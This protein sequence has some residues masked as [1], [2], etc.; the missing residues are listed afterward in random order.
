MTTNGLL[1][2]DT[3]ST[4]YEKGYPF[5][6]PNRL[7]CVGTLHNG[8]LRYHDIEYSG[9]PYGQTLNLL[10]QLI[11]GSRLL[12]GFNLKHDLHWLRRY[13]PDIVFPT[14]WDCQLAEFI[15]SSQRWPYPSLDEACRNRG[16]DPK[17]D[18]IK[19]NYWDVG[20]DTDKVP[21]A[22]L[23][24]YQ[25]KDVEL[26]FQLYRIQTTLLEGNQLRLFQLQNDDLQTLADIEW[27]GMDYDFDESLR[28]GEAVKDELD[29]CYAALKE[30]EPCPH[31]NWNSNKHLS[32]VLYGG[33]IN[34]EGTEI[35]TKLYKSGPKMVER[36]AQL[37]IDFPQLVKPMKGTET[38]PTSRWDDS[39]LQNVNRSRRE[40]R[41]TQIGRCYET[42]EGVLKSLPAR[43]KA[44]KIIEIIL[45]QSELEKLRG[46]YYEGL[47]KLRDKMQ[48]IDTRIHGSINQ[49]VAR[50]GRTSSSGPN[51]Q[52]F[53]GRLKVL[54]RSR[55]ANQS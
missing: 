3:E 7:M 50:T 43:G 44:R 42:S 51:M 2:L 39:T 1:V 12:V 53:D 33:I 14:L 5:S 41:K 36:K 10:K 11:E 9:L 25:L 4:T 47:P 48:Y 55:Y 24:E 35:V 49:C 8:D 6:K 30:L 18:L 27:N 37:H 13:I 16:L 22:I 54:F 52:N 28:R 15:L 23:Q 29:N 40:E 26:T 19:T 34:Y 46:T 21:H 32:A 20:I 31:I 45:K 17:L 38:L